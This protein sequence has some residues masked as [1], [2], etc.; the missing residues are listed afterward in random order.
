[1]APGDLQYRLV[2]AGHAPL[3]FLQ[4]ELIGGDVEELVLARRLG[5]GRV[6]LLSN[7]LDIDAGLEVIKLVDHLGG[8]GDGGFVVLDHLLNGQPVRIL[9]CGRGDRVGD[10]AHRQV[11]VLAHTKFL[12]LKSSPTSVLLQ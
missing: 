9:A 10:I 7:R 11:G 2:G 1:M 3:A 5:L 8:I 4:V 12:G 6:L